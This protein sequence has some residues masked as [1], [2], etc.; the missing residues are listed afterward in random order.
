MESKVRSV[1]ISK[2][3]NG[4]SIIEL[5]VTLALLAV[6]VAVGVPSFSGLM[7]DNQLVADVNSLVASLQL[8]RS[9]SVKR[10]VQVSIRRVS[11]TNNQWEQGWIVF[12]DENGNGVFDDNGDSNLCEEGEDCILLSYGSLSNGYTL[13]TVGGFFSEW[14][15][16]QPTGFVKGQGATNADTFTLCKQETG[17]AYYRQVVIE[18]T[19]RPHT[20]KGDAVTC[21]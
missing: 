18:A 21:P 10:G 3:N 5:A 16:Y 15:A 9:E 19:G 20:N 6:F 17:K 13:S 7:R 14:F 4:F 12:T 11:T 1:S 8:A 2:G